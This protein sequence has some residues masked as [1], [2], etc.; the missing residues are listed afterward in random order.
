MLQTDPFLLY[1]SCHRGSRSVTSSTHTPRYHSSSQA[2]LCCEL[3]YTRACSASAS[4]RPP[5]SSNGALQAYRCALKLLRFAA[6]AGS[7]TRQHFHRVRRM[8]QGR[9]LYKTALSQGAENAGGVLRDVTPC[10]GWC[11]DR[12]PSSVMSGVLI[13]A[14]PAGPVSAVAVCMPL[15][16]AGGKSFRTPRRSCSRGGRPTCWCNA[17]PAPAAACLHTAIQTRTHS[18]PRLQAVMT[19]IAS[20]SAYRD[21]R[22]LDGMS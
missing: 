19:S 14:G 3:R 18:A 6:W 1:G 5:T 12:D 10:F 2:S 15:R 17:T 22:H 9:A 16:E 11:G 13:Q 21:D 4:A 8:L 7:R 20:S